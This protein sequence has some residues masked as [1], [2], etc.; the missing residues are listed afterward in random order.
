MEVPKSVGIH[1]A[2]QGMMACNNSIRNP[3]PTSFIWEMYKLGLK[4]EPAPQ[5]QHTLLSS[6][7][8]MMHR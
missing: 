8:E 6:P 2:K 1:A 7:N 5:P 3:L 4:G